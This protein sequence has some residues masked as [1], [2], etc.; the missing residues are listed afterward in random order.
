MTGSR[1]TWLLV[2]LRTRI[3]IVNSCRSVRLLRFPTASSGELLN[4]SSHN[5]ASSFWSPTNSRGPPAGLTGRSLVSF[6]D[7]N[8][9]LPSSVSSANKELRLSG[10][11]VPELFSGIQFP[12][13]SQARRLSDRRPDGLFPSPSPKSRFRNNPRQA[14]L[15]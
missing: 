2:P 12:F 11:E 1:S 4:G 7:T 14:S 9:T 3:W 13:L 15:S 10:E 6:C 8:H 5:L